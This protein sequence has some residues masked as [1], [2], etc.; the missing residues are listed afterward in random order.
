MSKGSLR[1]DC[2]KEAHDGSLGD[3]CLSVGLVVLLGDRLVE[4]ILSSAILST[5]GDR[6]LMSRWRGL[7]AGHGAGGA[8]RLKAT[9]TSGE[10][11]EEHG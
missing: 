7:S 10:L 4:R 1:A 11:F 8:T 5:A 9:D 3:A 6:A 2:S